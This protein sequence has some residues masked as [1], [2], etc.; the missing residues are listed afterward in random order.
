VVIDA[1]QRQADRVL[2][3]GRVMLVLLALGLAALLVRVVQLKLAPEPRLADAVGSPMSSRIEMARR[4]SVLDRTGRILASSTAGWRLFVDPEEV[5]DLSTIAVDLARIIQIDPIQIERRLVDHPGSRY[6]IVDHLLD[7]WQVDA[8]TAAKL[9]GIGLEPRLVREYHYGGLAA[10]VLGKVGFE[11]HGLSGAEGRFDDALEPATGRLAYLRDARRRP[12]WIDP[13]GYQRGEDGHDL[14]LSLD[15]VIQELAEERLARA[16]R[17]HRAGGGRL[18][19]ADCI[20]GELLAVCDLLNP[21]KGSDEIASAEARGRDPAFRASRCVSDPYEPG[22]TF[23]PFIWSVATE[24]GR[25]RLEEILPIPEDGPHRTSRG[26]RIRDVKAYGPCSWR[27]VLVKSINSG[28]AIVAERLSER[29]MQSAVSRFGFGQP[30]RCGMPGETAGIVTSPR[31]W[32]HYTQTSVAMG[33][34]IAVTPVQMVRGFSAFARDG[35][36]PTLRI[37]ALDE[38]VTGR[39][40]EFRL[41]QRVLP[42]E[43]VRTARE[44]MREVMTAGTGRL[45]ESSQYQLFAK[46]GTAQLPKKG[47]QGYYEDRYVSSFIAG[48]PYADPRIVVLCVIDDPDRS[49]GHFGG[50]IAGPVVR[51]VVEG[52]LAYL[53]VP[54]D[55]PATAADQSP[56]RT[57]AAVH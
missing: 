41:I 42:V 32:S 5:D 53:G 38:S 17:E 45:A 3:W 10:G 9:R 57:I 51:D 18:I 29:E 43:L 30:T 35:T 19:V 16:M 27:T 12:L 55:Q 44:A 1:H 23:K 52:T 24:L 8:V 56:A 47:G 31:H 6:V 49:T 36:L 50:A 2:R 15:V 21:R 28:M 37:T 14:R 40:D 54:S 33:H 48:A 46:S 4:G 7:D 39:Q 22:S 26:R 25:A 11:N 34:E 13:V 20:T